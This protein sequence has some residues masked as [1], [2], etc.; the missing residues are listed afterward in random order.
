MCAVTKVAEA[1]VLVTD[2]YKQFTRHINYI[3]I[4]KRKEKKI[5]MNKRVKGWQNV[6][7]L[8]EEYRQVMQK[9]RIECLKGI[10]YIGCKRKCRAVF[11]KFVG[12]VSQSLY[13]TKAKVEVP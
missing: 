2:T 10:V 9:S 12:I 6:D 4:Q 3:N 8:Y 1:F 5:Y 13:E 7:K 11:L